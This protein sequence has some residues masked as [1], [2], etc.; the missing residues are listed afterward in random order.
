MNVFEDNRYY[1]FDNSGNIFLTRC[2]KCSRENHAMCVASGTC[3]WCNYTP[4]KTDL[5]EFIEKEYKVSYK[6]P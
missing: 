4:T 1:F 6:Q 5:I 2:P 3:C